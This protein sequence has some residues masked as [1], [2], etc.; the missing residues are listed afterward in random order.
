M[1]DL[2]VMATSIKNILSVVPGIKEAYD[3][4]PQTM[5]NF[6]AATLY[7]DGFGQTDDTTSRNTVNWN[8]TIRIYIRLNTSDIKQPQIDLR[9]LIQSAINEFRKDPSLSGSCLWHTI[10]NGDVFALLEQNNSMMVAELTL[11]AT[12]EEY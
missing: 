12:T 9:N 7:F 8:W 6:P 1:T 2:N 3:Y 10:A 5:T 4:E 11:S